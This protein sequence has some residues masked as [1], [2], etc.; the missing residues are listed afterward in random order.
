MSQSSFI[1]SIQLNE[2]EFRKVEQIRES[3]AKDKAAGKDVEIPPQKHTFMTKISVIYD[4]NN[5]DFKVSNK[6]KPEGYGQASL[7]GHYTKGTRRWK[8]S[9]RTIKKSGKY[10]VF[11]WWGLYKENMSP[12][13]RGDIND[14]LVDK[15]RKHISAMRTPEFVKDVASGKRQNYVG[16]YTEPLAFVE[17]LRKLEATGALKGDEIAQLLKANQ[18]GGYAA[19]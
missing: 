8:Y 18:T 3:R 17:M 15:S 5:T 6:P 13:Q 4:E 14:D 7:E 10:Y 11:T 12:Q 2:R 19:V 9:E 16:G 1:K